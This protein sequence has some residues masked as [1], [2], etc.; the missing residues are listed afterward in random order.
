M[1]TP[2]ITPETVPGMPGATV[3]RPL[4]LFL[5]LLIGFLLCDAAMRLV[6]GG[7]LLTVDTISQYDKQQLFEN[8]VVATFYL[9]LFLQ[10]ML[11]TVAA[12][13]WG[14]IVFLFHIVWVIIRYG[15]ND[16]EEWIALSH[17]GRLQ[18]FTQLLFF[19]VVAVMLNRSPSKEALR[20]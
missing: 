13:I 12:R 18:I 17:L 11:R 8:L 20:S 19:T 10:I 6:Q 2:E 5:I 14:T 15:I 7:V 4:P 16:P 1:N 3:R 9:L